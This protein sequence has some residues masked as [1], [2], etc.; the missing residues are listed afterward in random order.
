MA[1]LKDLIAN[2]T[3]L[4][5]AAVPGAV[6]VLRKYGTTEDDSQ[7]ITATT[8]AQGIGLAVEF[9]DGATAP[10]PTGAATQTTLAQVLVALTPATHVGSSVLEASHVIS[11]APKSLRS[12]KVLNTSASPLYLMVFDATSLPVNGTAPSRTPIPVEAGDVNGDDWPGGTAL[13]TGCVVAL[14]S[15]V[16]TL[17]VAGAVGWFDAEVM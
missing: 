7:I 5:G 11:I 10:L 3:A 1:N 6:I 9:A 2:I 4:L 16:A 17:T 8:G 14:S 15:T 12:A 13:A